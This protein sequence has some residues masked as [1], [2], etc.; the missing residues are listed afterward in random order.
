[1]LERIY[2]RLLGSCGGRFF[3][4]N[5]SIGEV[6]V[7]KAVSWVWFENYLEILE[8]DWFVVE[9][10]V[11]CGNP[12]LGNLDISLHM[13]RNVYPIRRIERL[14]KIELTDMDPPYDRREDG[15]LFT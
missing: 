4:C 2:V 6:R 5:A 11:L 8:V 1:V 7:T 10:P 3:G 15:T 13:L 9:M 12:C 14:P